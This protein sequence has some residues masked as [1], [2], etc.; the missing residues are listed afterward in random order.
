[1]N[2]DMALIWALAV[3]LVGAALIGLTGRHPNLRESV[4]LI[5]ATILLITVLII[6]QSVLSGGRPSV[7]L[8]NLIP[9]ISIAFRAEPLGMIFAIVA[10]SLWIP[11]SVY[12]IGY[13]RA[14]KEPFQTR[15]Y[16][17]FALAITSVMGLAFSA[18]L[19]T[20]FLFYETLTLSTYP[21]VTHNGTPEAKRAG[22]LY[23]GLL[24][25]TSV[26]FQL[27]A[28][29]LT[30]LTVGTTDFQSGGILSGKAGPGLMMLLFI[31]FIFGV[32][33]A[34]LMPFHR[35]LPAA[36]VAPTP[37]SALLHAV[38]VV[39][40]GVFVVLKI[41]IYVF[42]LDLMQVAH[43]GEWLIWLAAFTILA[44]SLIAM[45]KDN[46]KARLAY[47]TISQLSYIVLG[48][49]LATTAS[50]TGGGLHL[51]THAFGKITLFFCAGAII[52]ATHKSN[53]SEMRGIGR[54]MPITMIAF[55][56]GSLS[57]I[58]LPPLGGAWSK[59]YLVLGAV[60]ADKILFVG[61]LMVSSLLNIA[62][63][64]P[65]VVNAF[66]PGKKSTPFNKVSE[67]PW[68]CLA[69]L[70]FT[71]VGCL[72]LFIYPDPF[73]NLLTQITRN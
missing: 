47:S 68:T 21:L 31:L 58:G 2:T 51:V 50:I 30:Y 70:L 72:I 62:Y 36:M 13:M 16:I 10:S 52:T 64:I 33:K 28:I 43:P 54:A 26:G 38:A 6:T 57:V 55:F 7:V 53:I 48:A 60:E 41:V 67:A 29:L 14:H 35:W 49:A 59:W 40:G 8:F 24:I 25:G 27:V 34:A 63:L 15:Y 4:T 12:S 39:K 37:V 44:S 17:C 73:F 65:I 45:T 3:P 32:G 9:N 46:L 20:M 23:L 11:N 69:P 22:R 66:F 19:V 5:T 18:N 56:I 42:G 1:M 61:V 71:S